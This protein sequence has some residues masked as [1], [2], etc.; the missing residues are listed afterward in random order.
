M[1]P[2]P[3]FVGSRPLRVGPRVGKGGEGEVYSIDDAAG[4]AVKF[5]TVADVLDRQ[6]KIA[7]MIRAGL[8]RDSSPRR[9]ARQ[10]PTIEPRQP[11]HATLPAIDEA[12]R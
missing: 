9:R 12:R 5:Y 7:A 2:P 11:Q 4:Q 3:L 1:S 10:H 6:S 8:A